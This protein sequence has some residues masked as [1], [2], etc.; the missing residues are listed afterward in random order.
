MMLVTA[1]HSQPA[2]QGHGLRMVLMLRSSCDMS[3]EV[4]N[5]SLRAGPSSSAAANDNDDGDIEEVLEEPSLQARPTLASKRKRAT[6]DLS[7]SG[8]RSKAGFDPGEDC[9]VIE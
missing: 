5:P 9:E 7:P 3:A 6:D 4:M 1:A 2:D 8:K